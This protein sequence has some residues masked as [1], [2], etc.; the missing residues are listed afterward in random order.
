MNRIYYIKITLNIECTV[1]MV[2]LVAIQSELITIYCKCWR[3]Y[4]LQLKKDHDDRITIIHFSVVDKILTNTRA[5]V[6]WWWVASHFRDMQ[7]TRHY[8]LP[9]RPSVL[10][11]P[12]VFQ[13]GWHGA[14][15][16]QTKIFS[17]LAIVAWQKGRQETRRL[18]FPV[19]ISTAARVKK[20]ITF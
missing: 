18:A 1:W 20:W 8:C 14:R 6:A 19:R 15:K 13:V 7:T 3:L 10:W 17:K 5:T 11:L 4:I 9:V 16:A 12:F 2:T